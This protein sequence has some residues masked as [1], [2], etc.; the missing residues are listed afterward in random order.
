MKSYPKLRALP[1]PA[2]IASFLAFLTGTG[3]AA[4]IAAETLTLADAAASG[5]TIVLPQN[6]APVQPTAAKELADTLKEIS[7]APLTARPEM[8]NIPDL[9]ASD[10][11]SVSVDGDRLTLTTGPIE[12]IG[13]GNAWEYKIR[14]YASEFPDP[15]SH[16]RTL[17]TTY[18][19][20][21]SLMSGNI[22]SVTIDDIPL[23]QLKQGERYYISWSIADVPDEKNTGNN[24]A[25]HAYAVEI[26]RRPDLEA[27]GRHSKVAMQN[28]RFTLS[29]GPIRN[30][31]AGSIPSPVTIR[32]YASADMT[33]SENRNTLLKEEKIYASI[34]PGQTGSF[35]IRDIPATGLV[36]DRWYYIIWV[37]RDVKGELNTGNNAAVIPDRVKITA[38]ADLEAENG[39]SI[40][41]GKDEISLVTGTVKNI[42]SRRAE[43][44]YTIDVYASADTQI[45]PGTDFLLTSYRSYS[46]LNPGQSAVIRIDNIPIR[47]LPDAKDYYI[48]WIVSGVRGET[49]T[50]NNTAYCPSRLKIAGTPDLEAKNG[51]SV[52]KGGNGFTLKTGPIKN[53]GTGAVTGS[54][55]VKVYGSEDRSFPESRKILLKEERV[56]TSVYPGSTVTLTIDRIPADKLPM[57]RDLYIGWQITGVP[58]ETNAK[59]NSACCE[60]KTRR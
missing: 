12:N 51:G 48:G 13:T 28:G 3:S 47:K 38:S 54:Y 22:R 35:E 9:E 34:S 31:G 1:L 20:A 6:P 52:S 10:G 56:S 23:D 16:S 11:G 29:T 37:I 60:Q 43:S 45:S 17:L 21:S 58:G 19:V 55:T 5:Y 49:E 25:R 2:L 40:T 30:I 4:V 59:N 33:V 57:N 39:G 53:I 15:L 42:G 14:V 27:D 7:G 50:K 24:T 26:P 18:S 41:G 32:I 36:P 44:P 8:R 46:S